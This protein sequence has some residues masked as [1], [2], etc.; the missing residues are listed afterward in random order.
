MHICMRAFL[1][2]LMLTSLA[3]AQE[4]TGT[5]TG[6]VVDSQGLAVAGA[7]VTVT[8]AQG[9]RSFVAD[10]QGRFQAPF[11]TPGVYT[12][13]GEL[14]GFRSVQVGNVTVSLGQTTDISMRMEVG[15]LTETVQ[16]TSSA[17]IVDTTSTTVG[18]TISS[19]MLTRV[20]VG[21]RFSD[22]LYLAPGVTGSGSAGRANPSMSGGSGLDNQYVINM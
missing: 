19:E 12:V 5:L 18:A 21:R 15:G 13:R 1:I 6:R 14:Q 3:S 8:G 22:T 11:L 4:T 7:T 16:V 10:D 20:P 9:S 17:A 2:T